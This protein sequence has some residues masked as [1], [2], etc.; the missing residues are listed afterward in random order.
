MKEFLKTVKIV[1][2]GDA[3]SGKTSVIHRFVYDRFSVHYQP[4]PGLDVFEKPIKLA[5]ST[6][7]TVQLWDVAGS[8][9]HSRGLPNALI[10]ADAIL[11][12]YDLTQPSTFKSLTQWF[13]LVE[14]V[15]GMGN[16]SGNINGNAANAAE[17]EFG[18]SGGG[19]WGAGGGEAEYRPRKP[20][21]DPQARIPLMAVVGNKSDLAGL[22]M[23]PQPL[24]T[25]WAEDHDVLNYITSARIAETVYSMILDLASRLMGRTADSTQVN[26]I[27]RRL[28]VASLGT[29]TTSGK[30]Q[31]RK[32]VSSNASRK[33][34]R[35]LDCVVM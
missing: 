9:L 34:V 20:R 29:L 14:R 10:D 1:L 8:M 7:C 17:D 15:C 13:H 24:H 32:S 5:D 2:V 30:K 21:P 18:T 19:G 4:T 28:S 31:R 11:L 23:V 26:T 6:P 27:V 33:S 3:C 16:G 22:R 35:K 25:S 12:V